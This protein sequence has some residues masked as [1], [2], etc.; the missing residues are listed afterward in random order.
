MPEH[1]DYSN[2]ITVALDPFDKIYIAFI[3]KQTDDGRKIMIYEKHKSPIIAEN[4]LKRL[5]KRN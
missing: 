1:K 3:H 5:L 4:K 2:E